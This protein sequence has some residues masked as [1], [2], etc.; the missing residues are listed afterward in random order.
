MGHHVG[1]IPSVVGGHNIELSHVGMVFDATP[2]TLRAGVAGTST[3]CAINSWCGCRPAFSDGAAQHVVAA[4]SASWHRGEQ[5]VRGR[6]TADG[7]K[8]A[9]T[10]SWGR[11]AG[12]T[13]R[14]MTLL[15]GFLVLRP[16]MAT[17]ADGVIR[18]WV[19][20]VWTSSRRCG[21][22][23]RSTSRFYFGVLLGS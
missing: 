7:V 20:V 10:D 6:M 12:V 8:Q 1:A 22:G 16:A 3:C 13:I 11:T 21:S 5:V 4:I 19:D 9:V 17:S 23:I 14:Y 2:D 18:R 15:C